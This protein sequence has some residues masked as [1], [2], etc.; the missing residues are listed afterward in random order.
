M[1]AQPPPFD[2]D[3]IITW[4]DGSDPAHRG[5]LQSFLEQSG[6]ARAAAAEPTRFGDCGEIDYCVASLLRF[7][8]WIRTIHIV[9]DQQSPALIERLKG[10]E[11]EH[12]VR[13]VDHR[14]FFQGFEQHLP[15]FSN[16]SIECLMWRIPGLAERFVY[17]NDDFVLLQPLRSEDFFDERGIV[18]RGKWRGTLGHRLKA[19]VRTLVDGVARGF[20]LS[21]RSARA[22]PG[23]HAAQALSARLAGF[24]DRYLLAPHVPHPMRKSVLQA[25]FEKHPDL[26]GENVR[27]RLRSD[28]QFV[29]TALAAHLELAAGS[30]CIDNSRGSV[31]LN[32]AG[33]DP[34]ALARELARL[35]ADASIALCCV[36]SLDLAPPETQ[37]QV[38]AWLDARVGPISTGPPDPRRSTSVPCARI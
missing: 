38:M 8:P 34:S 22:R 7:A 3:A 29:T 27:H 30:A 4:V 35:D 5:R 36:Q 16:R 32:P 19:Q 9:C 17:L 11:F 33:E 24:N 13:I 12:R 10:G 15:T 18:L 6:L 23:N 14:D 21:T 26:I 25:F 20:G 1:Q 37:A 28:G 2:I 31:R